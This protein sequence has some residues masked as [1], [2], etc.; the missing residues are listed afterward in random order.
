MLVWVFFLSLSSDCMYKHEHDES[1]RYPPDEHAMRLWL[2]IPH[3]TSNPPLESVNPTI[4]LSKDIPII[5]L[6]FLSSTSEE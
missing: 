4:N 5:T 2:R 3:L 1:T 6:E